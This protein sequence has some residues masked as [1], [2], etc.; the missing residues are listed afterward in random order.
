MKGIVSTA[1]ALDRDSSVKAM[2]LTSSGEKAFACGADIKELSMYND[3]EA[4]RSR[5][6]DGWD[7]LRRVRKPLVAAVH[8]YALGGGC[9]LAM[10]CDIIVAGESAK[11]G[12]PE[13]TLGVIPGMGGTQRLTRLV[14]RAKAMELILTG[15]RIG[16]AEAERIGLVSRVV[17]DSEVLSAA[18]EIAA[19]IAR[20]PAPAVAKAKECVNL[21]D[22]VPLT[23][24]L[25]YERREFWSAFSYEG[26]QEG[27]AAF[28]EKREPSWTE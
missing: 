7:E 18:T 17:P 5:V 3:K 6:F 11:F 2:V 4:F 16:A 20:Y 25:Q 27:M 24:G 9:E 26:K 14:G 10:M 23:A 22:E 12:Q 15:R 28:L 13:I 1:Q 8:G 21:V 19:T